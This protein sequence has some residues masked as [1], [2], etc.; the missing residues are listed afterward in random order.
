MHFSLV[1]AACGL[2]VA[3]T[4]STLRASWFG[5]V[6]ENVVAEQMNPA[7][8]PTPPTAE[9]P[10]YYVAYDGGYIEAGD[11]I[12]GENPPPPSAVANAV[13]Q[14][15]AT[16]H[17][18]PATAEHAPS[19]VLIYHWG[20]L[21]RDSFQ[22]RNIFQ[23]Q[24]NLRARIYLVAP[25]AYARRM[26]EDIMDRRQPGFVHI[27]IID[28]EEQ[29][30]LQLAHDNRYFVILSA[31]DYASIVHGK[32]DLVWRVRMSTD[33]AGHSMR[34]ALPALLRGA[35]PYFGQNHTEAL[36]ATPPVVPSG[37]V[38]VGTPKVEE[39]LPP[40]E[41]VRQVNQTY[42]DSVIHHESVE[43]AGEHHVTT[44]MD[45]AAP[46][47]ADASIG[48]FLPPALA[49]RIQAYEQEKTALQTALTARIQGLNP[50]PETSRA[51]DAFDRE[52]APRIAKLTAERHSIRDQL[53]KLAAANT[54]AAHGKTLQALQ[55]EFATGIHEMETDV[56]ASGN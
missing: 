16:Q 56:P 36:T 33:S 32:A 24:P 3:M 11:P 23:I 17:Y 25:K 1:V 26:V 6:Y 53:A 20:L 30:L 31:Y 21:N 19:L 40:P 55:Q 4:A 47:S 12:A 29:T 46:S 10:A 49:T 50:G 5:N 8:A 44:A 28:P 41:V 18:L 45:P 48:S 2:G 54:D 13:H 42:L 35:A 38:K 22:I 15:L 52:N 7:T 14:S 27:P 43:F 37:Q 51:I 34:D 39:F 9:H